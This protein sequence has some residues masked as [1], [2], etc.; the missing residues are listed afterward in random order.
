MIFLIAHGSH[1]A[2][3]AVAAKKRLMDDGADFNVPDGEPEIT[4]D[5]LTY[6]VVLLTYETRR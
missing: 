6:Y 3:D 5:V 4:G 2:N 1:V